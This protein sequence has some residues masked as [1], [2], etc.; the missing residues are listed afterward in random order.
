M[1][2]YSSKVFN[3]KTN[4]VTDHQGRG[5]LLVRRLILELWMPFRAGRWRLLGG[6]PFDESAEEDRKQAEYKVRLR[7]WILLH[8]RQKS[9]KGDLAQFE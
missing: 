6:Q 2:R 7:L 9:L 4:L 8:K 5:S 3:N 1:Q